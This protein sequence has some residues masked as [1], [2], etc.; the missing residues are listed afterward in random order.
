[1]LETEPVFLEKDW[2][3]SL[4]VKALSKIQDEKFEPVFCGGTSLLHAYRLINRFSEDVDFRIISKDFQPSTRNERRD[5][6]E[7]LFKELDK[8]PELQIL[9]ETVQSRDSSRF[10]SAMFSYQNRFGDHNSLRPEIKID[11]TFV[12][13]YLPGIEG[14]SVKSI[15]GDY[16][17][18]DDVT[19]NCLSLLETTS[20]KASALIWRVLSRDRTEQDDDKTVIRHLH[21]LYS[22]LDAF[23]DDFDSITSQLKPTYERD[24]RRGGGLVNQDISIAATGAIDILRS[25]HEYQREYES[26]VLNMCFGLSGR[27]ISFEMALERFIK[28]VSFLNK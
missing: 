22:L 12:E 2:H 5:F 17:P 28:L 16:L 11:G 19:I 15:V 24:Y 26:F 27:S 20:D 14:R 4:I 6:R 23:Q 1:M 9:Q 10:F 3:V 7:K 13:N 18:V 21:D 8:I 25:D